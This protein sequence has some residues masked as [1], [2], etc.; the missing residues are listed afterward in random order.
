ML[1]ID[2][3]LGARALMRNGAQL[4]RRVRNGVASLRPATIDAVIISI[5]CATLFL[6]EYFNDLAPRLFEFALD[7]RDWEIDNFVF[8]GFVMSIGSAIFSYRRMRELAVEI[9]AR[10]GAELEA[11]KLARHDPLTGLPNRRFF[12]ERLGEVLQTTSAESRSAVLMLDLD[13]FKLVND[14]YGH[15]VGD[16]TLIE[17]AQRISAIMRAGAVVT[18]IG[19]DEFAVIVPTINSLDGPSALA[20]RIVAAVGEP[21]LVGPISTS[22]GVCVG[23]AVAP[24]DGMDP[25]LLVQRADRAL[26]RAK[27]EGRSCIRFFETDMDAHVERRVAIE[28]ALR[29]AVAAKTIVPYYQPVVAF[30]GRRVIGFEALARWNSE[31]FG[32][33]APDIFIPVAEEIDVIS[34]LGDQLLRQACLDACTWPAELTLAFNISAVQLR[35]PTIGLRVL[36]ILAETGFNP[37]RL[38]LEITE[39]AL[40]DNMKIAQEIT[41]QLRQAGVRIVLDDFGTGYA[42]LSHLLSLKMDRIKIDRSF[43]D[44][45]GKNKESTTIVR[46]VLGLASG[47]NLETTAEGIESEEQLAL[48]RADG[49]LEGQGFLFGKAVSA[50]DVQSLLKSSKLTTR[51]VA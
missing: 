1:S 22:V 36:A 4:A 3:T 29:A 14:A 45:L 37:R 21:F 50:N 28:T 18:R 11:K 42:T 24:S 2:D 35:D 40:V 30:A 6:V 25:E 38:E 33:V 31:K 17:F 20:R 44:R 51:A 23:I 5:F 41:S 10:R 12:L 13:G 48:L 32:W 39:T 16:Q 26:Y 46:A 27:S 34:E 8:V 19:G 49:C 15:T 43:V 47:F 7:Y 9:K